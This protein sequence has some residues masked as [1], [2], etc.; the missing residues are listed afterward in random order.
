MQR[1]TR[2]GASAD[3]PLMMTFPESEYLKG[4]HLVHVA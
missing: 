3:H 2:L 4:P 1:R